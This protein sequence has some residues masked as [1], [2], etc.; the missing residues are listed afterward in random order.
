MK[1]YIVGKE[2]EVEEDLHIKS[3][4]YGK[5]IFIEKGT[6][7]FMD[8]YANTNYTSGEGKGKLVRIN[9]K[10]NLKGYDTSNI[11]KMLLKRLND[12]FDICDIMDDALSITPSD[13]LQEI[14]DVLTV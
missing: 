9:D 4:L 11:A 14:E 12:R 5:E 10:K 13:M 8:A 7:G 2:I 1:D 3:A 6:K